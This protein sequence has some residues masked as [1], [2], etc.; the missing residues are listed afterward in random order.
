MKR[1]KTSVI[2]R[3]FSIFQSKS[4]LCA[5]N[6]GMM[7]LAVF[8][9]QACSNDDNE[10]E[11][12]PN[13]KETNATYFSQLYNTT[14]QKISGGDTTWKIFK[15]YAKDQGTQG[16]AT[17]HIIV[18]VLEQAET[19]E[20]PLLSDTV[21][22]DYQGRLLPSTSYSKG[23][24]FDQSWAGDYN[25]ETNIPTKF[26]VNAVVDGFATALQKMH[27]GDRWL[28][29]I[30]QELGYRGENTSTIPAY[31]TLVFDITL[32]AFYK[33]GKPVPAWK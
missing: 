33:P 19:T 20:S 4:L 6:I 9:F 21:R 32:R 2:F 3:I 27:V 23:I 31:S 11:E 16:A 8:A 15:S 28:V 13:W 17:E 26:A 24:V 25:I 14:L 5:R 30:P 22:V 12:F 10:E 1:N 29:Y 18:H 7:L